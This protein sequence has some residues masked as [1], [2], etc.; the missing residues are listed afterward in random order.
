MYNNRSSSK[1]DE[2]KDKVYSYVL[3]CEV[4]LG[5]ILEVLEPRSVS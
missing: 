5:E 4:A 3:L 2:Q 1:Y